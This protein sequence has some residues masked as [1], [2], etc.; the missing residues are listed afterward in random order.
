MDSSGY[1]PRPASRIY[2]SNLSAPEP[3]IHSPKQPPKKYSIS[4]KVRTCKNSFPPYFPAPLKKYYFRRNGRVAEGAFLLRKYT[5]NCIE[6]SNPSFS[7]ITLGYSQ[8]PSTTPDY[9]HL[10]HNTLAILYALACR[11]TRDYYAM[12]RTTLSYSR[13]LFQVINFYFKKRRKMEIFST[14]GAARS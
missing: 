13:H 5:G 2:S 10:L 14:T 6:G 1:K 12:R 8:L 11:T 4:H 3:Q 9:S 7:A